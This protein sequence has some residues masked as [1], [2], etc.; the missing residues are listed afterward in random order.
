MSKQPVI[1]HDPLAGLADDAGVAI[2]EAADDAVQDAPAAGER[3]LML[4]S[5][6]TIADVGDYKAVMDSYIDSTAPVRI[7]GSNVDAIDG[8]G[9]QLLAAFVKEMIGKSVG[10]AWTGASEPLLRAAHRIGLTDV[11]QLPPD[12]R[13]A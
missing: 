1:S 10:V 7:D 9:L 5:T 2:A 3:V 8:A 6:L 13:A 11:L 12:D 4:E